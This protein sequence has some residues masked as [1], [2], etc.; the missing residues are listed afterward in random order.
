MHTNARFA[1]A[2]HILTFIAVRSQEIPSIT[3]AMIAE[4]V[5]TN[6]VVIRRILGTLRQAN[7]VHSQPG[8]G[9][10]WV[11]AESADAITL[12]QIYR[13]VQDTPL[14][15]VHQHPPN[16]RCDVGRNMIDV[17]NVYFTQAENAIEKQLEQI[18]IDQVSRTITRRIQIAAA[19]K[20]KVVARVH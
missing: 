5:D 18:T 8:T 17:L 16:S 9:G 13:A 14:F 4:S 20:R 6:P 12:L 10:G 2:V 15:A 7:L 1:V 19:T 3:S 11:L